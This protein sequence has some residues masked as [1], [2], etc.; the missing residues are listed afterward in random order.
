M[1]SHLQAKYR[2][3][4]DAALVQL[5]TSAGHHLTRVADRAVQAAKD[6]LAIDDRLV[7]LAGHTTDV[8]LDAP[9]ANILTDADLCKMLQVG[10]L[11]KGTQLY[12]A[13]AVTFLFDQGRHVRLV[14]TKQIPP[15]C[16]SH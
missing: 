7:H 1:S 14:C 11:V 13:L 8:T 4:N 10:Q 3:Y 2:Q 16:Q 5:S 12:E 6:H 15:R 9:L